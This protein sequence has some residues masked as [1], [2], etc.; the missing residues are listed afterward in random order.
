MLTIMTMAMTMMMMTSTMGMIMIPID[1]DDAG[2]DDVSSLC[3]F[4]TFVAKLVS[5]VIGGFPLLSCASPSIGASSSISR[6]VGV[7]L[8]RQT[9]ESS[10]HDRPKQV[11]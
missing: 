3:T 2:I 5:F 6:L 10:P 8:F 9:R 1:D 7:A 4:G 11:M